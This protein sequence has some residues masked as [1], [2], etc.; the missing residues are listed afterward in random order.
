MD[1]R[2]LLQKSGAPF[3]T[4][5]HT[6]AYSA[7]EVAAAMHISGKQFAKA[8]LYKADDSYILAVLPACMHVDEVKLAD[9]T[10]AKHLVKAP[11]E[12]LE[13][14]FPDCQV[15]AMPP[16]GRPY[17]VKTVLDD[18]LTHYD[19][20]AFQAGTHTDAIKMRYEDYVEIESPPIASFAV[21]GT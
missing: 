17:G 13:K 15:G 12:E 4:A 14:V 3:E 20:I 16:F 10:G 5:H 21:P 8:V 18:A 2:E 7:N 9:V 11:E 19:E 1:V 6:V